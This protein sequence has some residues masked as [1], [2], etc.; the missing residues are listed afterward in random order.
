M[1]EYTVVS[2]NSQ[3]HS[4]LMVSYFNIN[5]GEDIREKIKEAGKSPFSV[6][7]FRGKIPVVLTE[8]SID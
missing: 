1:A 5:D 3:D 4:M 8:E 2:H 6:V 7:I